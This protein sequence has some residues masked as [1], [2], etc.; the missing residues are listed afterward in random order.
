MKHQINETMWVEIEPM[1]FGN[2]RLIVTDGV[3][4]FDGY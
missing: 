2:H 1:T 4:V 3:S